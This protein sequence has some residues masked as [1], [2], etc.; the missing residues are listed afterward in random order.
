[1]IAG[2]WRW[3]WKYTSSFLVPYSVLIVVQSR[4]SNISNLLSN[5]AKTSSQLFISFPM[6][7]TMSIAYH[8]F[9]ARSSCAQQ[10][11]PIYIQ[12]NKIKKILNQIILISWVS[13][14]I[15]ALY[16]GVSR[17]FRLPLLHTHTHINLIFINFTESFRF[18]FLN[19][20][21][22]HLLGVGPPS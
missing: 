19:M 18:F 13:G 10:Q 17:E 2:H 11:W 20:R 15:L 14:Q 6:L 5:V 8:R 7:G 12:N 16:R 3:K 1:M 21:L 9:P 4:K 22:V